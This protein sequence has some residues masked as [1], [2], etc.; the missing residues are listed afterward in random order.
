VLGA[1]T[2]I[3]K[4][5]GGLVL[6]PGA[7][8][9]LQLL[10]ILKRGFNCYVISGLFGLPAYSL[11]GIS[12]G[13]HKLFAGDYDGHIKLSRLAQGSEEVETYSDEQK[14]GVVRDWEKLCLLEIKDN[15]A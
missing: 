8:K 11:Q 12:V 15:S 10:L 1:I 9:F 7:G 13:V 3:G 6:K 2:G 5:I 4:G 14:D